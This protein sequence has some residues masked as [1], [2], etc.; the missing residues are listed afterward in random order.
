MYFDKYYETWEKLNLINKD[1]HV[2]QRVHLY[3]YFQESHIGGFP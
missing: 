3:E 2:G 1:K